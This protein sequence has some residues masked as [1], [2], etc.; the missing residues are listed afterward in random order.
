ML[1]VRFRQMPGHNKVRRKE[2]ALE[3][4]RWNQDINDALTFRRWFRPG[5]EVDMSM[6]FE[7][8]AGRTISCPGCGV[9]ATGSLDSKIRWSVMVLNPNMVFML[10]ATSQ[11]CDMSYQRIEIEQELPKEPQTPDLTEAKIDV[12]KRKRQEDLHDD[13]DDSNDDS[14]SQFCR[15]RL[16]CWKFQNLSFSAYKD[17]VSGELG[18]PPYGPKTLLEMLSTT[19]SFVTEEPQGRMIDP[20]IST[21]ITEMGSHTRP[22]I[23]PEAGS[24]FLSEEENMIDNEQDTLFVRQAGVKQ[25]SQDSDSDSDQTQSTDSEPVRSDYAERVLPPPRR[26][27]EQAAVFNRS[28]TAGFDHNTPEHGSSVAVANHSW[29]AGFNRDPPDHRGPVTTNLDSPGWR[30][31]SFYFANFPDDALEIVQLE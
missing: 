7:R 11:G 3:A 24:G 31:P 2:Y 22:S 29:T 8:S 13:D 26:R 12:R 23:A 9:V 15:V 27:G 10:I 20:P 4:N 25:Q 19:R 17:Q 16:N 28:W 6:V 21:T 5:Q 30:S 14:P 1:E 18:Y